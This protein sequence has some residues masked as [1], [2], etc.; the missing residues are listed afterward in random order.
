[1][2]VEILTCSRLAGNCGKD[3]GFGFVCIMTYSWLG[4]ERTWIFL[5][6]DVDG[7]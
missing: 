6:G 3:E 4:S 5:V 7:C 2:V 1:M